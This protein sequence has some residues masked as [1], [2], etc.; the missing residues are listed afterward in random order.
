[1]RIKV[2]HLIN[3]YLP[4]TQGW[5]HNEIA[6]NTEC[7]ACVL[8]RYRQHGDLFPLDSVY[9]VFD[10]YGMFASLSMLLARIR[11]RYPS[12]PY[13][14]MIRR[15]KP[16]LLHGHFAPEAWRSIDLVR[17]TGLPLVV[18]FYGVDVDKLARRRAWQRRY[19]RLFDLG[20]LFI[21]EGPHMASRI[22]ALGCPRDKIRVIY[23]AADA[24]RV[25]RHAKRNASSEAVRVLY[26]GLARR[27][28]GPV[29]A[30][31]A[32]AD[33][34][35]KAPSLELHIVGDGPFRRVTERIL[36]RA[37]MRKRVTYHGYV[38]PGRYLELLGSSDILLAPSIT[39]PDGDTEG[40]APVCVIE[41]LLAGVPV[42]GT[43]HCDIPHIVSH[44][45][46]GLVCAEG[47]TGM[48]AENLARL[49]RDA[50][51]RRRMAERA[52]AV[53]PARHDIRVRV[54]EITGAYRAVLA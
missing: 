5:M 36:S 2:A 20:R 14:E 19:L 33:A 1:M 41:S 11:A 3:S 15:E 27:K 30:V 13:L 4:L 38:D 43:T 52:F 7:D 31:R 26:V 24:E 53:A 51:M 44:G 29:H 10:T 21:A 23:Q 18:T 8:C 40:G 16:H 49:A 9:P 32:F 48:L 46:T 42:V 45:E 6:C 17:A 50:G 34:A 12:G 35:R 22:A 28:K 47:D 25:R 37:G 39:A 54:K